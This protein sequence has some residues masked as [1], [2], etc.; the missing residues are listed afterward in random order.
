MPDPV[1]RPSYRALLAV[2]YLGRVIVSMQLARV[3][4]SMVGVAIVL[5]ALDE[6]DSPTL[7][8]VVTLASILPGLLVSPIAGAL[9]DRHGRIR[10]VALDYVVALSALVLI[11][12]L[13][14]AGMLPVPLLIGI[15][16]VVADRHPERDRAAQPVPVDGPEPS[17]SRVNAVDSNGY[18]VA[19]IIGPPLARPWLQSPGRRSR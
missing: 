9:L 4:Q 13:S 5:F 11:G 16:V 1:V 18:V 2:P 8:G 17:G 14:A 19:T 15:T 12:L 3:A 6:Y 7:A 10:L